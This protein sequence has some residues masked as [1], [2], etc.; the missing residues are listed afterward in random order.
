MILPHGPAWQFVQ[1]M[2]KSDR[3]R[4]YLGIKDFVIFSW[5]QGFSTFI[6]GCLQNAS[7]KIFCLLGRMIS[8]KIHVV[9]YCF[10]IFLPI[11]LKAKYIE[12]N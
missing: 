9:F 12:L 4:Q 2:N 7:F 5:C 10:F 11:L 1:D 6:I 8:L 3:L